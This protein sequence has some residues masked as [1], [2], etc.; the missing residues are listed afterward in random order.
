MQIQSG[1]QVWNAR[2]GLIL[3]AAAWLID[4][5]LT[6]NLTYARCD[7]VHPLLVVTVGCLC[8]ALAGVGLLLSWRASRAGGMSMPAFTAYLG[9]LASAYAILVVAAGTI[10]GLILPGCF[11]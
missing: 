11:R 2:S 3:G 9:M 6:S 1:N 8:A 7:L 5:Q 4:Q 10:A